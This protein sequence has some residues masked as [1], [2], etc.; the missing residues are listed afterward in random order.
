M[1]GYDG[2]EI[3][4][5]NNVHGFHLQGVAIAFEDIVD[6][7]GCAVS[8]SIDTALIAGLKKTLG[9]QF[10]IL[11]DVFGIADNV[12]IGLLAGRRVEIADDQIAPGTKMPA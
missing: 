3:L 7:F 5:E 1:I 9:V 2:K 6:T 12:V 11:I 8:P 10:V 4:I